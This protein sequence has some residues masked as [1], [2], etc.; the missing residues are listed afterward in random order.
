MKIAAVTLAAISLAA[1]TSAAAAASPASD[2]DYLKA[3][4]CRGIAAGVGADAAGLDA[5]LKAEG[6]ARPAYIVQRGEQEFDHAKRQA[7]G[8]G[9]DRLAAE[10]AGPCMAY[11]AP[12][13]SVAVR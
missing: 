3:S 5:Y 4:R 7:R 1:A 6:V 12:A 2:M 9:K 11:T 10:L 13:K 8:E